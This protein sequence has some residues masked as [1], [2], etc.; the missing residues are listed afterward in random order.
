MLGHNYARQWVNTWAL[1]LVIGACGVA[2][3]ASP[4]RSP[5]NGSAITYSKNDVGIEF[6][7]VPAGEF[8]MGCSEGAK[9]NECS[10]DEKPRHRVQITKAFEIGKTEVTGEQ[11]QAVMGSDPSAFKGG[12]LPVEQVTFQQ[13]QEFVNKLNTR[14]DGFLYRL[15]TEAE[16]EYAARAGTT[17]QYAGSLHDMAWYNDGQA[18]ARGT[19]NFQNENSPTGLAVAKAHPVAT[20]SPNAWGIYDTRGNV[21]EWVRDFYDADYCSNIPAIDPKGPA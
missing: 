18:A 20:K 6:V 12:N 1:G 16:W 13:V 21:A 11:W 17:D 15:P 4:P 10:K 9:P 14:N 8:Q 2:I 5:Q 7:M 3:S 19:G